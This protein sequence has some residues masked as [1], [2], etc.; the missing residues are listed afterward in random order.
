MHTLGISCLLLSLLA[1][2]SAWSPTTL[3]PQTLTGHS[4]QISTRRYVS[5]PLNDDEDESVVS[6]KDGDLDI[7]EECLLSPHARSPSNVFG[8]EI[9]NDTRDK[10]RSL[11]HMIKK[12]LFDAFFYT[13]APGAT[14]PVT[15]NIHQQ[16]S[17]ASA[18]SFPYDRAFARFY[19][20][21]TIARMPYFSYLSVLHLY[22]TLGMWRR[23]ETLQLHFAETLNE[24]HHLLIMEE[25]GGNDKWLDRFV[26]QHIAFGYY[27][28]A[29]AL[30]LFNPTAA[31]NLNEAV[32]QEAYETYNRFLAEH[33][34]YLKQQAAPKTAVQYYTKGDLYDLEAKL[35]QVTSASPEE[36]Q[37]SE[38]RSTRDR[39][40]CKTLYD[41][42]K[43]IRD[44]EMEHVKTMMYLQ[45]RE[46]T[47]ENDGSCY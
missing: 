6:K 11:V 24:Q 21:E 4:R 13:G 30:F 27:V 28:F 10:N 43:N 9:D 17:A 2:V 15:S 46:Q 19:A 14:V 8:R 44:D 31:Y 25:L 40:V 36:N 47:S 39:P 16:Q 26:A 18:P 22:E 45:E 12:T 23:V 29:I 35:F 37:F 1:I 20:L 42:F 5:L 7:D 33:E 41:C 3:T 34:S 32:E 38:P